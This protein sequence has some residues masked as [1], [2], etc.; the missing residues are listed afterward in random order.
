M[1]GRCRSD[2]SERGRGT[3]AAARMD[4]GRPTRRYANRHAGAAARVD[5]GLVPA[6]EA[7]DDGGR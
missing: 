6:P 7:A 1:P 4:A 3:G 5:A 2:V